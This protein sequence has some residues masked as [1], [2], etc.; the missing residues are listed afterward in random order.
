MRKSSFKLR[1]PPIAVWLVALAA[2]AVA[3]LVVEKDFLWKVQEMNLFQCTPLFFNDMMLMPGG[4][5]SYVGTFLTQFLHYPWLGVLIL[6]ACWLLL[7]WLV[8]RTF[9]LPGKW[10]LSTLIPV[11]L[12]LLT[13]VDMGYWVY[14]LK[15]QGHFF[16]A[17]LG[18]I[19][20]TAALWAFR[21][22]PGKYGLRAVFI[23][24]TAIV[25]YPLFGIYGLAATLLMG[26]LS[27]RLETKAK[28]AAYSL[29]ALLAAA[30]VPL[31][32]YRH[33]YHEINVANVYWAKLPLY[34]TI[35]SHDM[36]YV[37]FYL[38]ALFFV[39]LVVTYRPG[40]KAE[41]EKK[42]RWLLAQTL[43][44]AALVVAIVK[45]WYKDENFHRELAMQHL[46]E[47]ND[48]N[49]VLQEAALQQDEPTRPVVMMR[50]I[51]LARL[52]R[53]STEMFQYKNGSKPFNAPF[54]MLM[55][56]AVAG[57]L[58][59]QNYGICNLCVRLST[60]MGVE[61]G[62]RP[63]YYKNLTR[64]AL[65][66]GEW[67]AARKYIHQLKNTLFFGDWAAH[68]ESL[69]GKPDAIAK[70]LELG[71]VTH[72]TH[73][74]NSTRSDKGLVEEF[75]MKQLAAQREVTDPV[76]E[77]Q[78]LLASMWTKDPN[79]FWYHFTR[80]ITLHPNQELP[81]YVEEAA[82]TF[83]IVQERTDIDKL[84]FTD[85]VKECYDKFAEL[86]TRCD[87]M[88][89]EDARE[90]VRPSFGNTFFYDYFLMSNLPQY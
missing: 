5:L 37:P 87:G 61:F 82:Y 41:V 50:N 78:A 45:G 44:V 51:A 63:E 24:V 55:M 53:Q 47:Q 33:V 20:V 36:Y 80:Y 14:I 2:I 27:W 66:K 48:W 85:R 64:C 46:L 60:E 16:V 68:A 30:Y 43:I 42:W 34:F 77:E 6:S 39:V 75:I 11:V 49:G 67:Q 54:Q 4:L 23:A 3:L 72:M 58:L 40:R 38:L 90:I 76:F 59:Y 73:Y 7:M 81:P 89:M 1:I 15:L 10:V 19:F 29:L 88:E 8:K 28:S 12:L 83:C 52:G 9:Q 57:P 25:G 21:C 17:T 62:W 86:M 65:L 32:C 74:K 35:E 13:I 71:F 84:P 31:F 26:I 79:D 56:P 22:L 70:D 18:T 69:V